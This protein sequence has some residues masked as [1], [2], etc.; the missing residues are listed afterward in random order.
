M[1]YGAKDVFGN[2][3]SGLEQFNILVNIVTSNQAV[4]DN[5]SGGN[6]IEDAKILRIDVIVTKDNMQKI[7]LSAYKSKYL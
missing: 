4:L 7:L 6:N 2:P 5:L 3:I 1:N